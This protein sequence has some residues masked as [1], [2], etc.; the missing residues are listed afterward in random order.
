LF[1]IVIKELRQLD[2]RLSCSAIDGDDSEDVACPA[3]TPRSGTS[4]DLLDVETAG[5]EALSGEQ[6]PLAACDGVAAVLDALF[7]RFSEDETGFLPNVLSGVLDAYRYI[8]VE[9]LELL[10][11]RKGYPLKMLARICERSDM[12]STE[13]VGE[14]LVIVCDGTVCHT[15]GA[16]D[17]LQSLEFALGIR[18]G[19]TT[20]D[21][22]F[23]LRVVNCVGSC[24]D[25]PIISIDGRPLGHMR[26]ADVG[27]TLEA[28]S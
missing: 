10:A 7:A 24:E 26:L 17:L 23:T 18:A 28:C 6:A 3:E 8:P 12:F 25:A 11:K 27:K 13:P 22:R 19:E 9:A 2:L 14:H 1:A 15:R 4:A 16:L 21:G 20:P 5:G